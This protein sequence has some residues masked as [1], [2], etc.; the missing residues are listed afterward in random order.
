MVRWKTKKNLRKW[1]LTFGIAL[2]CLVIGCSSVGSRSEH[3]FN[4]PTLLW[5]IESDAGAA[6]YVFGTIHLPDSTVFFQRDTVLTILQR[7]REFYSEINLDSALSGMD[8]SVMMLPAGKK[9]WDFYTPSQVTELK[10]VLTKKLGPMS[11]MAEKLK[12]GAVI[13]LLAMDADGATAPMSVDEFLW[14]TAKSAGCRVSGL[15]SLREQL[16]LLDSIPPT[17]LLEAA[18]QAESD[19]TLTVLINAY[20]TEDLHVIVQMVDSVSTLE[21][22]MVK[23]ND[24]RNITMAQ[25]MKAAVDNGGAFFA[26]GAAHLGGK[27][28]L[29]AELAT[30]GYRVTPVFGGK[31]R[32]W[33]QHGT[34]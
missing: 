1:Y 20:R 31:R 33:L 8:P 6:S 13:A 21:T 15:E 26:V 7:C 32:S 34:H 18:R 11:F 14:R 25:R 23:L 16:A 24:T 29:L 12:P 5:K 19:S 22:F 3:D 10:A 30:L 28:G 9:L 2:Q 17:M 27:Q 4:Q